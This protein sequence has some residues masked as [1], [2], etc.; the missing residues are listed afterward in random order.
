MP[1]IL[2]RQVLP[3]I[4]IFGEHVVIVINFDQNIFPGIFSI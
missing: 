3:G 2:R 4:N 1:V